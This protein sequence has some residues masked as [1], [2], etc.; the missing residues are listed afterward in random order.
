MVV[1]SEHQQQ[2]KLSIFGNGRFMHFSKSN[3]LRKPYLSLIKVVEA[4]HDEFARLKSSV[5]DAANIDCGW[6]SAA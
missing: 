4:I 6:D 1:Y 2:R 3:I 5:V